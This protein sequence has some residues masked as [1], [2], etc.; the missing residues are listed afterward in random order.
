MCIIEKC[1][2]RFDEVVYCNMNI[3]RAIWIFIEQRLCFCWR[4][5]T[6]WHAIWFFVSHSWLF[7]PCLFPFP[8][9]ITTLH[10]IAVVHLP[11]TIWWNRVSLRLEAWR[12]RWVQCP[13]LNNERS[14]NN[15]QPEQIFSFSGFSV[16]ISVGGLLSRTTSLEIIIL[17]SFTVKPT[18]K[19]G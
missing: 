7:V 4:P 13:P 1:Y 8:S 19:W 15:F 18:V 9:L 17:R 10:Y 5:Y 12:N 16:L 14:T 6:N 2:I 3:Y 11:Y